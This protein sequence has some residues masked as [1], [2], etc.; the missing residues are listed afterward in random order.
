MAMNQGR[1]G[2]EKEGPEGGGT[3][4][5]LHVGKEFW[6]CCLC[7]TRGWMIRSHSG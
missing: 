7:I 6:E 3:G 2:I 4:L 5:E 1:E